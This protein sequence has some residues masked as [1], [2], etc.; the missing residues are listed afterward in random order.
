MGDD[1]PARPP[2]QRGWFEGLFR[3][4]RRFV[5]ELVAPR[6]EIEEM[7]TA[8]S[9]ARAAAL[10]EH[11]TASAYWPAAFASSFND[12]LLHAMFGPAATQHAAPGSYPGYFRRVF[13][14]GLRPRGR[15]RAQPLPPARPARPLPR[16]GRRARLRARA[17][18]CSRLLALVLGS[19]QD[20]PDLQ[21]FDVYSLSNV[22]DWSDDATV[23][24]WARAL[25]AAARPGSA[26][27][28]RKLNNDRDVRR[29]FE[30][31]FAFDDALPGA[32]LLE[33]DRSLFYDR[34]IGG[35][36]LRA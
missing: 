8:A 14:R 17:A 5:E 21:R 11:W 32:S 18:G 3:V 29:F 7:F 25:A 33:R 30:P 28:V 16:A 35:S 12:P 9:P 36:R 19:L 26:V 24:E 2:N 6:A 13:E 4:L 34:V 20:V 27:L 22:L 15:R 23:S 31:A 10:V 1:D